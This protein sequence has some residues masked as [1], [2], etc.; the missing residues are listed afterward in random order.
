MHNFYS[1]K[2]LNLKSRGSNKKSD[3]PLFTPNIGCHP[4]INPS[5]KPFEYHKQMGLFSRLYH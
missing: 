2:I 1:L 5:K 3:K 4:N